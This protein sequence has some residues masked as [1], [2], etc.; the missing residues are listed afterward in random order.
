MLRLD[1]KAISWAGNN[2]LNEILNWSNLYGNSHNNENIN[3]HARCSCENSRPSSQV[4]RS[5]I[6]PTFSVEACESSDEREI[7]LFSSFD[8]NVIRFCVCKKYE[9]QLG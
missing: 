7:S 9:Q 6:S 8:S 4:K 3:I 5:V 1:L 2:F